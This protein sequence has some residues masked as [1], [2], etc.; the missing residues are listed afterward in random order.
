MKTEIQSLEERCTRLSVKLKEESSLRQD[1]DEKALMYD[2]TA[3]ALATLQKE[4]DALKGLYET[5]AT[6]LAN[7]TVQ[8]AA[9]RNAEKDAERAKELLAMDKAYL[10]QE[11]R[12]AEGRADQASK[13]NEANQS[14]VVQLEMKVSALSDQLLNAQLDS[15][16][17]IEDRIEKETARIREDS[18]REMAALKEANREIMERE[19][20]VLREAKESADT[21]VERLKSTIVVTQT[22]NVKLQTEIIGLGGKHA[23][24]TA[25]LRAEIKLKSFELTTLGAS[26]E[27]RMKSY[28]QLEAEIDATKAEL[29]VHKGAFVKL[30]A[31]ANI[32]QTELS[33]Q[34][35]VAMNR[36]AAYEALEE[37]I[38]GKLHHTL[39]L[40][41]RPNN[42]GPRVYILLTCILTLSPSIL[43]SITIL[44]TIYLNR[45]GIEGSS[46][47]RHP[48]Q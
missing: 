43:S 39:G 15:R 33:S 4:H 48:K 6:S 1:G 19:V 13:N 9:S 27:E 31:D 41:P 21:E 3:T 26:F 28:R 23:N 10:S 24:D 17:G 11:L 46:S 12:A 22:E 2:R 5:Q 16:K 40:S 30:E 18:I 42:T 35:K 45:C 34:L 25:E 8:E 37:E 44:F 29:H 7:L 38:D 14:K 36:L 47:R 32:R 20:K